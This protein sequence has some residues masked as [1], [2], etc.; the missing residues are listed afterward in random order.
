MFITKFTQNQ[1]KDSEH[2]EAVWYVIKL[3]ELQDEIKLFNRYLITGKLW[4][5][6][7]H[8]FSYY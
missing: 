3:W 1:F 6:I 7:P 2:Q 8:N 4:R 5:Y